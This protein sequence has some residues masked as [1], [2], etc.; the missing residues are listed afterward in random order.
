VLACAAGSHASGAACDDR[1]WARCA[2]LVG[3][4][5]DGGPPAPPN[6]SDVDTE[7]GD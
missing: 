6:S 3:P 2:A 5:A 4:H 7:D 1:A